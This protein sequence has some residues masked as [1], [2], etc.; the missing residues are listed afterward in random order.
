M[1]WRVF[2][3]FHKFL[4]Y[5]ICCYNTLKI[6]NIVN[7]EHSFIILYKLT[8]LNKLENFSFP[9]ILSHQGSHLFNTGLSTNPS[10]LHQHM[11]A[12]YREVITYYRYIRHLK[13]PKKS[14]L[15]GTV[16]L[17]YQYPNEQI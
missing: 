3:N 9:L 12:I 6:K 5:N 17:Q 13:K 10:Y 16:H 7:S 2:E 8:I 15:R 14:I 11:H 4:K 1:I